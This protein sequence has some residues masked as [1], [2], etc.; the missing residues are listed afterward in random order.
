[1]KCFICAQRLR[2]QTPNSHHLEYSPIDRSLCLG[3]WYG[4]VEMKLFLLRATGRDYWDLSLRAALKDLV[5]RARAGELNITPQTPE[6]PPAQR[7]PDKRRL[8]RR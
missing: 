5:N 3:C 1:M 8:A 2:P 7:V 4:T 6:T